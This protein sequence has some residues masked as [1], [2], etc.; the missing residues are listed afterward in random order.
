VRIEQLNHAEQGLRPIDRVFP[1]TVYQDRTSGGEAR[2]GE[3]ALDDFIPIGRRHR[4]DRLDEGEA[5]S[6]LE[7]IC[8][9]H[10]T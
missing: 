2:I 10:G 4:V 9:A 3:E 7:M 1:P 8:D 6:R 5:P